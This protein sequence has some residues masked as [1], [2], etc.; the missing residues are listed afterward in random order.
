MSA[1]DYKMIR[2]SATKHIIN[3]YK[4]SRNG[5]GGSICM[6]ISFTSISQFETLIWD[7]IHVATCHYLKLI[8]K[9]VH[10][11]HLN[12]LFTSF[13]HFMSNYIQY[14]YFRAFTSSSKACV[15]SPYKDG[16]ISNNAI[17]MC[18]HFF[19]VWLIFSHLFSL[20]EIGLKRN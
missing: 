9:P 17:S 14:K 16:N 13:Y 8:F 6:L 2:Y 4:W 10:Q 5:I 18:F 19:R 15:A 3:K 1:I 11:N 20:V 12:S 7:R